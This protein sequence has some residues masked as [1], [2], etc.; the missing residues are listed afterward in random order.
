MIKWYS[1]QYSDHP[2][3]DKRPRDNLL[4][5]SDD[6]ARYDEGEQRTFNPITPKAHKVAT[7]LLMATPPFSLEEIVNKLKSNGLKEGRDYTY[8]SSA[9][10]KRYDMEYYEGYLRQ[11]LGS[12]KLTPQ[13]IGIIKTSIKKQR[14]AE[15]TLRLFVEGRHYVIPSGAPK[16]RRK[17]KV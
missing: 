16:K 9:P 10:P 7:L 14:S 3:R 2:W 1:I 13:G 11:K 5:E 4:P 17:Q 15:E 12:H 6:G 8:G